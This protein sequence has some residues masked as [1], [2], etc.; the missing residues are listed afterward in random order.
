MTPAEGLIASEYALAIQGLSKFV[1]QLGT[2]PSNATSTA[3]L[4]G[5]T[6]YFAGNPTISVNVTLPT[7]DTISVIQQIEAA[8]NNL[9][10]QYTTD[11]A[12]M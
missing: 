4:V 7:A 6:L 3:S 12:G 2:V 11:L 10:A 8:C 1:I 5:M 9:I